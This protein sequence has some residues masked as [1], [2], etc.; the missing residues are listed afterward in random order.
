MQLGGE[1]WVPYANRPEW[2]DVTPL[3]ASGVTPG[4]PGDGV[5]AVTYSEAARDALGYFNAVLASVRVEVKVK[6][7][8]VHLCYN[9]SDIVSYEAP[10]S[11][12]DAISPVPI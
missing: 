11:L 4:S 5:T 8:H 12:P 9:V 6:S 7:C 2:G 1:G 3:P 10:G